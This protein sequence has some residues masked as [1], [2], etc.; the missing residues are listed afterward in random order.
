VDT[1]RKVPVENSIGSTFLDEKGHAFQIKINQKRNSDDV[2]A[3]QKSRRQRGKIKSVSESTAVKSLEDTIIPPESVKTVSI[4]LNFPPGSDLAYIKKIFISNHREEDIYVSP[5]SLISRGD[6]SLKISNFSKFPV[7]IHEGQVLG[8]AHNP[9]QWFDSARNLTPE[10]LHAASSHALMVK[11]IADILSK[12]PEAPLV[13]TEGISELEGGPKIAET[14]PVDIPKENLLEA[15]DISK[16]LTPDQIE[17]ITEVLLLNENAFSLDG[18]LGHYPARVEIPLRDGSKELSLPPFSGSPASC[19]IIDEQ[20][21]KWLAL[22]VIEPSQSPWGAPGFITYR[23]GKPRMVINFRGL[24]SQVIPDEF[25]LLRW[26][27]ILQSST[28]SQSLLT[29]DALA[30]FTQLEMS[31]K[32]KEK[33]AFRTHHSLFQF[34]RTPFGFR[35]GPAVFRRVMQNVLSP[36]LWIFALVYIDDIVIFSKTFEEH[37]SHINQVLGAISKSG[38]TLSPQKCHFGYQ[39]L[40]LL[41]QKVSRLGLSTHEEKIETIIQ[42][43][44]PGNIKELQTFLGRAVYFQH[45]SHS[46]HG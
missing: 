40:V 1:G 31:A 8:Y 15:V 20:M 45:I 24:N 38:I 44:A 22:K 46:M 12:K 19:Q 4:H 43:D 34:L 36:F 16:G 3:H 23:N 21:D 35:N 32:D 11:R 27:D 9:I 25:P 5:D 28:G 13:N 42:L 14:P 10:E 17:K 41:G 2:K 18:Q 30:G 6:S 7:R 33:M 26:E 29:L 37:L 39:S